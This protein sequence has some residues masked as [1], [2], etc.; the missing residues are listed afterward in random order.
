MAFDSA[1]QAF[2]GKGYSLASSE[3]KLKTTS[4]TSGTTTGTT[5]QGE[6]DDDVLTFAAAHYLHVGDRVRVTQ[7]TTLPTGLSAATDYFVKTVPSATTI[8]LSATRGGAVVNL[9]TDGTADN[10][11]QVMGPLDQVT[12][13]EA[14]ASTGDSRKVVFGLLEALFQAYTNTPVAD[15]PAKLSITRSGQVQDDSTIIYTYFAQV[16]T[17][18]TG[19]EVVDE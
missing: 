16:T 19:V 4:A 5:F 1:P 8:T 11:C 7:G 17:T 2:F 10:T 18:P 14:N 13:T 6:A 12:D 3:I 15:R 9:T